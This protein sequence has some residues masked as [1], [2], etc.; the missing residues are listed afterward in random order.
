MLLA[1]LVCWSV[2]GYIVFRESILK[3]SW[4]RG[5]LD[6][7]INPLVRA[8]GTDRWLMPFTIL[9]HYVALLMAPIKLSPDYGSKV[10][11]WTVRLSDPYFWIGVAS[12]FA[13]VFAFVFAW[14]RQQRA[15]LF[16]LVGLLLTYGLI[17]NFA[18]LIGTNFGERLMYLPS[19]FFLMF[20]SIALTRLRSPV[21][22]L[23]FIL[24]LIALSARTITYAA[25]WND[26]QSFYEYSI[27]RQ[28]NSIRLR[29]L[30]IAE[31][32]NQ[33]KFDEADRVAAEAREILPEYDEIWIQSA[34]IASERGDF[35]RAEE[36]LNHAMKIR[37]SNKAA[38]RLQ[39]L[40][41]QRAAAKPTS[42]K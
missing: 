2:A 35:D 5:F 26:R 33:R 27:A 13:C 3:F 42:R 39:Q 20:I 37:P 21:L 40:Y 25:R 16:C 24:L 41:D 38:G 29:M 31:L 32:E 36:Y 7:T 15:L 23:L 4:D 19:A 10:I 18:I 17:S 12:A 9:G 34:D 30:F 11:G 14:K 6:W 28:P 8:T 1:I 22:L